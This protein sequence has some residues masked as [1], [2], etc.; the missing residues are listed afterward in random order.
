MKQALAALAL[1]AGSFAFA[2][3]PGSTSIEI[4]RVKPRTGG[5]IVFEVRR[6]G[7]DEFAM[8]FVSDRHAI[9]TI[10]SFMDRRQLEELRALID[11]SIAELERPLPTAPTPVQAP[12]ATPKE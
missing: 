11:A 7:K 2:Q 5:S 3:I 4:G 6:S 12:L 9:R 1:L 10:G 8:M